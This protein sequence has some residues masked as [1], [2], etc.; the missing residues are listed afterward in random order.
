LTEIEARLLRWSMQ[1]VIYQPEM[2]PSDI[3]DELAAGVA[4]TRDGFL[5]IQNDLGVDPAD[6]NASADRQFEY[7]DLVEKLQQM[8]PAKAAQ[9]YY[10]MVGYLSAWGR[11]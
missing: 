11:T 1:G 9:L 2:I 3:G 4:D 5:N 10:F 6:P 7:T 8:A